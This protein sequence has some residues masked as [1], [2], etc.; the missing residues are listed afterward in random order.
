M[1]DGEENR[2]PLNGTFPRVWYKLEFTL[3]HANVRY[4]RALVWPQN[5]PLWPSQDCTTLWDYR[6]SLS[7]AGQVL[8]LEWRKLKL[9]YQNWH[10]W[11]KVHPVHFGMFST[12][13]S[14]SDIRCVE[15]CW[16]TC[17][18]ATWSRTFAR[19]FFKVIWDNHGQ[20]IWH[21]SSKIF[22]FKHVQF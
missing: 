15:I 6:E 11:F 17:N 13:I 22:L 4:L 20:V 8:S 10:K 9:Q 1:A 14:M 16:T 21:F 7:L 12:W 5:L 18:D 3:N 19:Y 2:P